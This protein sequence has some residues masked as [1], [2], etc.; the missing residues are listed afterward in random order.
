MTDRNQPHPAGR[1]AILL[2]LALFWAPSARAADVLDLSMGYYKDTDRLTV[3]TPSLSISTDLTE[4]TTLSIKYTYETFQKEA[5]NNA[6]DAVTGATTVSGGTGGGFDE[7]RQE[8]VA[9][10]SQRF[11]SN[12]IGV[13]YFY[14]TENDFLS[15]AYSV[16]VTRELFDNNLTL[17]AL[18]G[19]TFDEVDKL[20]EPRTG[21]PKNKD[22]DTYTIS[23]TQILTPRLL[24]S[25][26]YSLSEVNGFQSL[27]LRKVKAIQG[28]IQGIPIGPVFEEKHPDH[29]TR[30]TLFLRLRQYFL[31]RTSTDL[32]FSYY[33]DD[34][35]IHAIAAEPR[36]EHYLSDSVIVRFRYRFYTQT[37]ADFYKPT[38]F[39]SEVTEETLKTADVRLRD[40]NTHTAGVA[41]RLLG[42]T[43][44]DWSVLM[45]Y[46]RYWETNN[47]IKANIYQVILSIP[48]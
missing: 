6:A 7:V 33:M 37:A 39:A 36:V 19:K 16:A 27:P 21:F 43:I 25:G 28:Y 41:L 31:S 4:S 22:T 45:T 17:T 40:Y 14:G 24:I 12:L 44:Q 1:V 26:G 35:G 23:A 5:P 38:Y 46:D 20:D 18:Y 34:W 2:F 13:G 47:G 42:E 29:R 32:N 3:H 11:G 9:G 30:Q 48:Y 10:V 15:N 8:I